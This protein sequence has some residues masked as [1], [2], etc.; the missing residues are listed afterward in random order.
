MKKKDIIVI[1]I[2][3]VIL[4]VGYFIYSSFQGEKEYATVYYQ[5]KEIDQIDLSID[6]IYTYKGDYGS[7]SI[8]VV[9]HKYHAV[10]VEC[11]NHDCEKV[12]WVEKGS[13]VSIIC[14]PN[15][16]YVQQ[17]NVKNVNVD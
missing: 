9:D 16:I 11:P 14:V 15:N 1:L 10:N 8:E 6:K 13:N 5:N 4:G 7:F 3:L 2:L 12:G 17:K